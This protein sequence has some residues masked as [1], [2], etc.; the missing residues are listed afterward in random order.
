V[1]KA[2]ITNPMVFN[3]G[4]FP[5]PLATIQSSPFKAVGLTTMP[6]II[7][8]GDSKSLMHDAEIRF[9]QHADRL[10]REG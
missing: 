5:K 8:G 9:E 4:P 3:S 7:Y 2:L 10:A 6:R 1:T